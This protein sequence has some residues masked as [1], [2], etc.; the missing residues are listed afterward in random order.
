MTSQRL[1]CKL[2]ATEWCPSLLPANLYKVVT[3]ISTQ[4]ATSQR[5]GCELNATEWCP[6]LLPANLYKVV[7]QISTQWPLKKLTA[8]QHAQSVF[9]ITV[10]TQILNKLSRASLQADCR[11]TCYRAWKLL[12][13]AGSVAMKM[14][15]THSALWIRWILYTGALII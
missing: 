3:Q 12:G 1:A 5:L 2:H 8:G 4:W 10:F 11:S 7:T 6:W 15:K 9:L 14:Y 13:L